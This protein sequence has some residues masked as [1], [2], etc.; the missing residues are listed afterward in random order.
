[1]EAIYE[2]ILKQY[3]KKKAF[4]TKTRLE[5][6]PGEKTILEA[7]A[8]EGLFLQ[9]N[10]KGL[11]KIIE[12]NGE[13]CFV[14]SIHD[15]PKI[16][17]VGGGHVGLAI[18]KLAGF[19]EFDAI[20]IDDR[21][22]FV[23][24]ERFPQAKRYV[25]D[26]ET[27]LQRDFGENVYYVIVTRGHKDDFRAVTAVLKKGYD[28]YLG[29]IGSKQKVAITMQKLRNLGYDEETIGKIHAPIGLKIGAI[30]PEEIAVSIMAQIIEIKS[31][32]VGDRSQH[33]VF[34]A[35][36]QIQKGIIAEQACI[37]T[38]IEKAGS[39]PRGVG[40]KMLVTETGK[41]FGTIGGGAIEY[42]AQKKAAQIAVSKEAAIK[43]YDLSAKDAS[44]LGMICGGQ[45]KVLYEPIR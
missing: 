45:V 21:A 26:V 22:E 29:M 30:T 5:N 39:S 23:S 28:R 9:Q 31:S 34:E 43:S 16:V 27:A 10:I 3:Q 24:Q 19:I 42:A 36:D 20:V 12:E 15:I 11:P 25:E 17:I 14:E 37:V 7:S 18:A 44:E 41:V 40:S 2:E 32:Y 33:N 1:M 6:H 38:I 35:L 13:C 8:V 4:Y